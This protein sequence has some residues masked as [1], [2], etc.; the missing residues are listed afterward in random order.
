VHRELSQAHLLD[1]L[2]AAGMASQAGC[3]TFAA[4][5]D[6]TVGL[7]LFVGARLR[8]CSEWGTLSALSTRMG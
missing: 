8:E 5:L 2:H 1:Q 6:R 4:Q 7:A 3:L